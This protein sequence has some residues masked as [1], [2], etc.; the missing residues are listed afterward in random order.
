MAETI[1]TKAPAKPRKT[2]AKA[3]TESKTATVAQNGASTG[4]TNQVNPTQAKPVNVS[5]E[6]IAK[7]AHHYWVT[8]GHRHGSHVDHW[9]RA[10]KELR[11]HHRAS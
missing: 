10:E 8:D 11:N 4:N 2:A 9:L 1:K 3:A 7:L 6:E 5:R